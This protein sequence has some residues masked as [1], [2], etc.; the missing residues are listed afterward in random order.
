MGKKTSREEL[1]WSKAERKEGP[2]GAAGLDGPE[3]GEEM[4]LGG[5]PAQGEIGLSPRKGMG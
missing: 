1:G 3:G 4:G 5:G 2:G